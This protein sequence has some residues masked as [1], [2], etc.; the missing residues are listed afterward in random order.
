M[1]RMLTR[2]PGPACVN[3]WVCAEPHDG[4]GG[5]GGTARSGAGSAGARPSWVTRSAGRTGA[6]GTRGPLRLLRLALLFER[7]AGD[8]LVLGAA[9]VLVRHERLPSP[10]PILAHVAPAAREMPGMRPGSYLGGPRA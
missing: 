10:G 4:H 5:R 2:A 8:L 1:H 7:L 6:A 3:G 9:L